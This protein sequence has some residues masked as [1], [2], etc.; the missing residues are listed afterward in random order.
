MFA[1]AAELHIKNFLEGFTP[2]GYCSEGLGYWNYGFGHYVMLAETL[3]R[4]TDGKVDWLDAD[5]VRNVARFGRRMEIL[6][7]VYPAFADCKPETQP[8]PMLMAFLSRR[9]GWGLHDIERKG[10][11]PAM[12]PSGQLFETGL[13][14][15]PSG[16][17][18][19]P[20]VKTQEPTPVRDWFSDAG[21]YIG[22][23]ASGASR[24]FGVALKGGH[25]AEHHN[26]NDLGS[27]V[28]VCG[29]ST[30]L[31]DPGSEV[32]TARTFGLHRYDSK[33][34][35]SFGHP[36]PRVAGQLQE[37]GRQAAAKVVKIDFTDSADTLVFDLTAGYKVNSLKKLERSFVYSRGS[38]CKLVV[39]DV[40]A[41][42]SPQAFGTALVTF[43]P[44]KQLDS[45]H[46][47]VGD[48]QG[49]ATVVLHAEGGRLR[50]ESEAIKEQLP[51]G[52]TPTR[53]GIDFVE[54]V[55]HATIEMSITP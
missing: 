41:F 16:A 31:L 47:R 1:A 32:Y 8:Q 26:H 42:D 54:P 23:P 15:F 43:S 14:T 22:R 27:F 53:I 29:R 45:E 25:N 51:G 46:L 28:V 55:T 11:G 40:V 21:V 12:G 7:G 20:E 39:K 5:R 50:V 9:Y 13:Y 48:E 35:N 2:D 52:R 33:V 38:S 6:P 17:A 18:V 30:P 10:L 3:R 44:W 19:P 37:V 4:A 36:V 49:G 34:L 24:A